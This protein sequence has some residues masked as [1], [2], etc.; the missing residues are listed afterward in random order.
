VLGRGYT[1]PVGG[2]HAE[3]VALDRALRRHGARVVRGASLAVTLEPCCHR[4]RTGPCAERVLADGVAHVLVGHTDPHPDVRGKG[5]R[6]LRRAGV[7]VETG[8]LEAECREQHRGFLSVIEC[9]R[10]F[11]MLK[12]AASLD[13]RIATRS[14]ESRWI[15]GPRAR[16]AVHGLRA[17]VDA[18]L[19][20]AE[21]ALADDP[22]LTARRGGRVVHCPTRVVADSRLRVPPTARLYRGETPATHVLCSRAAPAARRRALSERGVVL[23]DVPRRGRGLDLAQGLSRLAELGI[24]ELLAEGG[25]ALAASLLREAL[26]DE[27]HWFVAPKLLGGDARPAVSALALRALAGAPELRDVR[28]R[29]LGD[30]VH[31]W[32]RVA[33]GERAR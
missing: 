30:D 31:V 13:G 18:I 2:D 33:S 32:G 12:L 25:G 26:V 8:I 9:G 17:S 28:V 6:R 10:P 7:V 4:G 15:T 24:T 16:A 11:V 20:G 23:I 21:T 5:L 29:R 22:E 19:V 1:Q 3:V 14:G 27:V